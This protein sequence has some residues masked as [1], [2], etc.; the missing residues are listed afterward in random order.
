MLTQWSLDFYQDV[1]E[2]SADAILAVDEAGQ[3][4]YANPAAAELF[5]RPISEII[6]QPF[7]F[8]ISGDG[9]QELEI[10]RPGEL[11]RIVEMRTMQAIL[12][13]KTYQIA[14]LRDITELALQREE[15]SA[16]SF[17]DCLTGLYNR[18]GFLTLAGDQLK[19]AY[20]NGRSLA[21]I[22][23]DLDGLKRIN[24]T[25]GH[26][27]GDQALVAMAQLLRQA[28]R[29]TDIKARLGGDEFVVLAVDTNKNGALKLITR[30][31]KSILAFNQSGK[32]TFQL[33]V[34]LGVSHFTPQQ[35]TT[36]D[37]LLERA[38]AELYQHKT[39]KK[40]RTP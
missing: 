3:V 36:L 33:S 26:T 15:L 21:L 31:E 9:P 13:S 10:I 12:Q 29:E 4:Y 34:S 22:Y 28:F 20:R 39:I 23:L 7:G 1:V 14:S 32:L 11:P 37:E 25:Y 30:L 5:A 40:G 17:T 24:D 2:S 19:M 38:D 6:A 35:P 18:R 27:T 16:L 8:P